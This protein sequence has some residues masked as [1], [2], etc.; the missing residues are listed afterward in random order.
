[1]EVRASYVVV[2]SFVLGILIALAV[3][4]VWLARVQIDRTYAV[5]EVAFTGSVNG[6]QQGSAVRYR[7]V[8]VGRVSN[9]RIDPDNL[10]QILVTLELQPDTPIRTD[11]LASVEAQGITGIAQ[12]QLSGG[13][14]GSPM[15]QSEDK[16]TPPR[17]RATQSRLEQVFES[18]PV[19]LNRIAQVLERMD[20]L[21]SDENLHNINAIID[22]AEVVADKMAEAMPK[23]SAILDAGT[24]AG[25]DI[26]VAARDLAA[27]TATLKSTTMS[28]DGRVATLGDKGA[29]TLDNVAAAA[30]SFQALATRLDNLTRS[31]SQPITD[32]SESTLY[33]LRQLVAELRQFVASASRITK[34]L[35]RDPAGYLLGGPQKGFEPR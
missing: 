6:V 7:G 19:V 27:L 31:N 1:M 35:E 8:P 17:I 9:I 5:Y 4:L 23:V 33:E 21:L 30:R 28:L 2:G 29:A 3:F 15:L 13:M 25:E 24:A 11:T 26:Q 14:Q 20:T 22:D 32:F 18:T 34:E 12:I 10:E 16:D